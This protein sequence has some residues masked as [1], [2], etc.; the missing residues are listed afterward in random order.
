MKNNIL[1]EIS[2]HCKIRS[3]YGKCI[4]EKCVLYRIEKLILE[5]KTIQNFCE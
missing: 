5:K 2:E 1:L 4:E 3:T